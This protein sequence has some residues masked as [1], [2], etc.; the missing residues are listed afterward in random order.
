PNL[1]V[2][3]RDYT[4]N[5]M[6]RVYS[7]QWGIYN[8]VNYSSYAVNPPNPT[9]YVPMMML[10][11]MNDPGPIPATNTLGQ[12]IDANG[13]VVSDRTQA[14]MITDPHYNPAYSNFCYEQPFMP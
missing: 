12:M 8:G 6:G 4:G 1:P 10:A 14:K 11:C 3:L 5:E 9:G 7:D 2:A 13:T